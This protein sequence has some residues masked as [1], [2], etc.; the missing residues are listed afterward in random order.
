LCITGDAR[1][2]APKVFAKADRPF[3]RQVPPRESRGLPESGSAVPQVRRTGYR[4]R[5]CRSQNGLSVRNVASLQRDDACALRQNAAAKFLGAPLMAVRNPTPNCNPHVNSY[6]HWDFPKFNISC[7]KMSALPQY[8]VDS[9]EGRCIC[10]GRSAA[11]T[12]GY[13]AA[14]IRTLATKCCYEV[15]GGEHRVLARAYPRTRRKFGKR[16]A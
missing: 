6:L 14:D 5:H 16:L 8:L 9:R 11:V 13:W 4:G 2:F 1:R 15:T 7:V 3:L 10:I 12:V